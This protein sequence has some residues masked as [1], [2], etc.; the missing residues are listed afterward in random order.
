MSKN[1]FEYGMEKVIFNVK[2]VLNLFYM[3]L[4]VVLLL[5][6]VAYTKHVVHLLAHADIL[7]T[8]SMMLIVLETVD[9][10]MIANLVKMIITGSYNSFV[11]KN[12]GHANENI[13]SG[14]LKV[15]MSTSII[16]VSS[17]HLLQTFVSPGVAWNDMLKQVI[18]HVTF[19]V[20]A[21]LLAAIEYIHLKGEALEKEHEAKNNASAHH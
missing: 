18:I 12:H 8:D 4:I 11:S 17:I 10:V 15:K 14:I 5:Y 2:W 19:L 1:L 7:T 21:L 3:G 20:G 13:S 6:S 16:G 9:I